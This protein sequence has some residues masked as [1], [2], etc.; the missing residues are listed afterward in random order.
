MQKRCTMAR[1][2][3]KISEELL[4]FSSKICLAC[5]FA[6]GIKT[7][8]GVVDHFKLIVRDKPV[9]PPSPRPKHRVGGMWPRD[10]LV[11]GPYSIKLWGGEI[12]GWKMGKRWEKDLKSDKNFAF[13][14]K[15]IFLW[16]QNGKN[17]FWTL[18][19]GSPRS[20]KL[21]NVSLPPATAASLHHDS[22]SCWQRLMLLAN[23]CQ[24]RKRRKYASMADVRIVSDAS[25][26]FLCKM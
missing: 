1:K 22:S 17:P 11:N 23:H 5:F 8:S 12:N 21:L 3:W 24:P 9:Y 20:A 6:D 25:W 19:K 13:W 14:L 4:V 15:Q 26:N 7:H 16:C 2:F 18:E 10:L